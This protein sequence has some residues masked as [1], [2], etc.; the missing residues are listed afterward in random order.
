VTAIGGHVFNIDPFSDP[1]PGLFLLSLSD[2][3]SVQFNDPTPATFRGVISS[4]PIDSILLTPDPKWAATVTDFIVGAAVPG[5]PTA[6]LAGVGCLWLVAALRGRA[7][8]TGSGEPREAPP[9]SF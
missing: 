4:T 3:T 7:L 1:T 5:P 8:N 6:L 2:G 9:P